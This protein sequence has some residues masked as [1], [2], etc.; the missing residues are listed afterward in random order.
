MHAFLHRKKKTGKT[1]NRRRAEVPESETAAL[2]ND[3]N[4]SC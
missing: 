2:R 3:G 4:E 1:N